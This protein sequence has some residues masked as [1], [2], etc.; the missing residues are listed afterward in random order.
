MLENIF[1]IIKEVIQ[2]SIPFLIFLIFC[3]L[4]NLQKRVRDLELNEIDITPK[5]EK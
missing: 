2:V 1:R 5:L 4:R 3:I